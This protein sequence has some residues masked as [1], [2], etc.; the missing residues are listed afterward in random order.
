MN[1]TIFIP[2]V[3]PC[4]QRG[5]SKSQFQAV[6]VDPRKPTYVVNGT[7]AAGVFA[8]LNG[9]CTVEY[10]DVYGQASGTA[11]FKAAATC[12]RLAIPRS[13]YAKIVHGDK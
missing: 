8:E 5:Y 11:A 13:G 2:L 10:F 9:P 3:P 7:N 6:S 1:F 12:A 4:C